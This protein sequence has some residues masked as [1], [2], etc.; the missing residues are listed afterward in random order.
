[1]NA[2][3]H[4]LEPL[5]SEAA[6]RVAALHPVVEQA[7]LRAQGAVRLL[8]PL[9][10]ALADEQ[11][12]QALVGVLAARSLCTLTLPL[13]RWVARTAESVVLTCWPPGPEARSASKRISPSRLAGGAA[14]RA[15]PK[16]Q[17]L[18]PWLGR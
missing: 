16:N 4:R 18:R 9:R 12:G 7:A 1:M 10:Q 15:P 2:G 8:G 6:H 11:D 14:N 17:F 3:S 5:A 13:A